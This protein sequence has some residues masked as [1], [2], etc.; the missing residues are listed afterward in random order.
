MKGDEDERSSPISAACSKLARRRRRNRP[1]AARPSRQRADR[2]LRD[3]PRLGR[4]S[5]QHFRRAFAC[6]A[7]HATEQFQSRRCV[8][9]ADRPLA[10]R[11][12]PDPALCPRHLRKRPF[13]IRHVAVVEEQPVPDRFLVPGRD[14]R[15][16]RHHALQQYR[17]RGQRRRPSRPGAFQGSRESTGDFLFISKPVLGRVSNKW[18]IQLTRRIFAQDGGFGGVVVVSL[19]PEYLSPLLQFGRHRKEWHHHPARP[20]RHCPRARGERPRRDRQIVARKCADDAAHAREQRLLHRPQPG[21]R[22]RAA[23]LVSQGQGLSTCRERRPG[24]R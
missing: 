19:D 4:R 2:H 12:G 17:R 20:R 23:G 5:P 9:G 1:A 13:R 10:P 18:S 21:G 6:R 22:H 7:G 3:R 8:R 14:H 24:H 15:S 16:K 11:R